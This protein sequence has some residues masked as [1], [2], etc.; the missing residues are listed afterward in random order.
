[1]G[2][3]KAAY[4]ASRARIIQRQMRYALLKGLMMGAPMQERYLWLR[5]AAG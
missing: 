5:G 1:M 4:V 3:R 2:T